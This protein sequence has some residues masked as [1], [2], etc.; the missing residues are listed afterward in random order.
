VEAEDVVQE[1]FTRLFVA[2][3]HFAGRARPDTWLHRVVLNRS[4]NALRARRRR[5]DLPSPPVVSSSPEE[6]YLAQEQLEL[7]V[8]AWRRLAPRQQALVWMRDVEGLDYALIARRL[9]MQL[10]TVKSALSRARA[11]MANR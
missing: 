10:G 9:G 3:H 6:H 2:P 1:V 4:L 8:Q 7:F 11:A 5:A